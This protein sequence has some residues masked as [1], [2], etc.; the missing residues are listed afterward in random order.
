M[1]IGLYE[2]Q[3]S[4]LMTPYHT[5]LQISSKAELTED[6][7]TA[8]LKKISGTDTS[9]I[10]D[11]TKKDDKNIHVGS[12]GYIGGKALSSKEETKKVEKV[13]AGA[14]LN[15]QEGEPTATIGDVRNDSTSTD[16]CVYGY[17]DAS[18]KKTL[19]VKGSGSGGT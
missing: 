19:V 13:V 10:S 12:A 8:K 17:A 11:A 2:K 14:P 6:I 15:F 16:W 3:I 9:Q 1:K 7:I 18:D 5:D 4:D